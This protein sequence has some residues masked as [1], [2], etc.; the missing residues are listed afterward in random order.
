MNVLADGCWLSGWPRRRL[1][2]A[3]ES[4]YLALLGSTAV[5]LPWSASVATWDRSTPS[6]RNAMLRVLRVRSG[7][8]ARYAGESYHSSA[9]RRSGNSMTTAE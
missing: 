5:Q 9:F 1:R 2:L 4:L 6:T 8:I 7:M 3:L